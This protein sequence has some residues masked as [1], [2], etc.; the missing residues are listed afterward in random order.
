MRRDVDGIPARRPRFTP[1]RERL[2]RSHLLV[3]S[4]GTSVIVAGVGAALYARASTLRLTTE[5]DVLQ[6]AARELVQQDPTPAARHVAKRLSAVALAQQ[7]RQRADAERLVDVIDVEITI[8]VVLLVAAGVATLVVSLRAA[9]AITRPLVALASATATLVVDRTLLD[10]LPVLR[11]DEVGLLTRTFNRMRAAVVAAE[12]ALV[13]RAT[14]AMR[15]NEAL[16]AEFLERK[17]AEAMFRQL[18]EATPD[19]IVIVDRL[20]VIVLVNAASERLFG[21]A[22]AELL[23]TPI[24]RILPAAFAGGRLHTDVTSGASEPELLAHRCDGATVP[25]EL[26]ANPLL[27]DDRTLYA[28]AVRDVTERHRAAQALREL[29]AELE[30]RV[31]ERTAELS[32][33]NAELERFAAIASHDLQEPLRMVASYVRLLAERYRGRLDADAD[34]FI[35][36][37]VD[38]AERMQRLVRDLLAYA[39]VSTRAGEPEPTDAGAILAR[40]LANLRLAIVESGATITSE[41]LPRIRVD[42]SQLGQLL[43]NL[44]DNALKFRAERAIQVHVGAERIPAGW[45]FSVRDNG[46]GIAPEDA[47]RVFALFER[48]RGA[49]AHRGS[50]IGLALC[51]KIVERHGGRIWV[52]PAPGGGSVFRFTLPCALEDEGRAVRN[53]VAPPPRPLRMVTSARDVRSVEETG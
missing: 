50:G 37:A 6:T 36:F 7:A 34:E 51:K 8:V 32:R 25:V 44:I 46:I 33:S 14:E 23:G 1:L 48:V 20:G 42:A 2:L 9:D 27:I 3:A 26:R 29:N 15:A 40:T 38:G 43:Q 22:R 19:A 11:E 52:E 53:T 5:P 41:P 4:I 10:D 24:G 16:Q 31:V 45:T 18:L 30:Q 39:R 28:I 12:R 13:E 49:A 35:A 47:V 17:Q 21:Y